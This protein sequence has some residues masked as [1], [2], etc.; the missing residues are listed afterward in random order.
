[1]GES[2]EMRILFKS[3]TNNFNVLILFGDC[4]LTDWGNGDINQVEFSSSFDLVLPR[5]GKVG[6]SNV[7]FENFSGLF[8]FVVE[9]LEL[10]GL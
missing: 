3:L 2:L 1:M 7:L 6:N 10:V 9:V 8:N 4:L 5:C